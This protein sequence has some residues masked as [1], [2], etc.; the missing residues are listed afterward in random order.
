MKTNVKASLYRLS[1]ALLLSA[2]CAC[3]GQGT[4]AQVM[5]HVRIPIPPEVQER[6]AQ[7]SLLSRTAAADLHAGRYAQ[8]EAEARQAV[9]MDWLNG[10]GL[11]VVAASLDAQDKEQEA[12]QA[13]HKLTMDSKGHLGGQPRT[14]L[15]YALLLLK[16]GQWEQ[17]V[18]AY[19]QATVL[20]QESNPAWTNSHFSPDVLDATNLA[21]MIHIARGQIYS[22]HPDWASEPQNTEAFAEYG[23]ALQLAPDSPLTNYYYGVGWHKL[24]SAEQAK[25]GTAQQAKAAL[26][27]AVLLGKGD[28]KKA[29]EKALKDF[30][31]PE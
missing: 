30:N 7:S 25:F 4:Q 13:Y 9:S 3:F 19:N 27:K 17:A 6:F 20:Y 15:P 28:V 23:K 24:S 11:E 1:L 18:A 8:A 14:L 22:A 29:A 16:S 12:L 31:K 2:V 26:Q 21:V 5:Q 10:E